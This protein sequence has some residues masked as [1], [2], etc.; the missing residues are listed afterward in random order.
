MFV[1][2]TGLLLGGGGVPSLGKVTLNGA[3]TWW[4]RGAIPYCALF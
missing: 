3:I 2:M 1:V 4:E